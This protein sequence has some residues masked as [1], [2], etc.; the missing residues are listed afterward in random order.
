MVCDILFE[1]TKHWGW[2][3]GAWAVLENHYHF[4]ARAPENAL[5]LEKLIRQ[6][7]SKTA[8]ALNK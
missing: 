5:T 1:R 6:L 8:V 2:R 7:H 4:I 3:L